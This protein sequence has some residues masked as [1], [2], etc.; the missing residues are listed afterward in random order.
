[1][2]IYIL[3]YTYICTIR[4]NSKEYIDEWQKIFKKKRFSNSESSEKNIFILKIKNPNTFEINEYLI[5]LFANLYGIVLYRYYKGSM[6]VSGASNI[7]VSCTYNM[8]RIYAYHQTCSNFH[9]LS[10]W[11]KTIKDL[12]V[13]LAVTRFYR[14]K[15]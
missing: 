10:F 6:Q 11:N 5:N 14:W 3:I 8:W 15:S 13:L 7:G 4:L 12:T 9:E 2:Y 1:M